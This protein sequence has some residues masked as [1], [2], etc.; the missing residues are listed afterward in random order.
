MS[1]RAHRNFQSVSKVLLNFASPRK[2]RVEPSAICIEPR[3]KALGLFQSNMNLNFLATHSLSEQLKLLF[4]PQELTF[5]V[6]TIN[7]RAGFLRVDSKE[8]I[9][10][11][12]LLCWCSSLFF[13]PSAWVKSNWMRFLLVYFLLLSVLFTTFFIPTIDWGMK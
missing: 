8:A 1:L 2:A 9:L 7:Q 6:P 4:L 11:R 3:R 13:S 10:E 12:K 5:Y